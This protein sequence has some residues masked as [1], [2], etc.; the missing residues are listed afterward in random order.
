MSYN[1]VPSYEQKFFTH[2]EIGGV[3]HDGAVSGIQNWN[4]G[5]DLSEA[6]ID[7]LGAG[8][9]QSIYSGPLEGEVS[10]SRAYIMGDD[11]VLMHTGEHAVSGSLIYDSYLN[12]GT[13]KVF[14]FNSGYLTRYAVNCSVGNSPT[15]DCSFRTFGRFGSGIRH[16]DLDFSG[17]NTPIHPLVFANQ[18]SI[19]CGFDREGTNRVTQVSQDYEIGRSPLY[20]LEPKSAQDLTG[21]ANFVPTEVLTNYPITVTTNITVGVDD[22]ETANIMDNIRSG[23]Y[24]TIELKVDKAYDGPTNIQ[25][26]D[27]DYLQDS[28]SENLEDNGYLTMYE[29]QSVTGQ[30]VAESIETAVDGSL[31]VNLSFK[32]YLQ[33]VL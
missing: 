19:T 9:V 4:A 22:Y 13:E 15:V 23:H 24:E 10:F 8:F 12:Q 18:G 17:S 20:T 16:G 25:D 3:T 28:T 5:Y 31:S 33:K 1:S 11:P 7:I 2:A 29:F 6:T 14:G 21:G 30:L 27:L 32:D 26:T